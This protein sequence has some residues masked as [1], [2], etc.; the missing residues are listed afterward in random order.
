[1]VANRCGNR[2]ETPAIF[3]GTAPNDCISRVWL[4]PDGSVHKRYTASELCPH[5]IRPDGYI[6][7]RSPTLNADNLLDYLGNPLNPES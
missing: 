2:I 5:L 4:A 1:M 3:S 6:G 7:W